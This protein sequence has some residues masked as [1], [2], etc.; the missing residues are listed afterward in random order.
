M[1]YH[2][3][4]LIAMCWTNDLLAAKSQETNSFSPPTLQLV[5]GRR[6]DEGVH[7]GNGFP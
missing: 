2:Y 5:H 4:I 7:G 1:T 6:G 3:P